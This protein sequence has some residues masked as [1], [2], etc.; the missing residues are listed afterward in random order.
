MNSTPGIAARDKDIM[1]TVQSLVRQVDRLESIADTLWNKLSPLMRPIADAGKLPPR[2][3]EVLA[4]LASEIRA[5]TDR[6]SDKN[7]KFE[8]LLD[9]LEI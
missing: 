7:D 4:P 6:I 8:E 3:S 2:V 1:L 9:K 5:C